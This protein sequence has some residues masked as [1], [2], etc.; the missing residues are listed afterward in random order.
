MGCWVLVQDV[1]DGIMGS[2]VVLNV[3]EVTCIKDFVGAAFVM[4]TVGMDMNQM[5]G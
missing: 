2:C 5:L 1:F 3:L 4:W